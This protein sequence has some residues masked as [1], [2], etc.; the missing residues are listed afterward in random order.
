MGVTS[1]GKSGGKKLDSIFDDDDDMFSTIPRKST[2]NSASKVS[3]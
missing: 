3:E 2:A 1:L